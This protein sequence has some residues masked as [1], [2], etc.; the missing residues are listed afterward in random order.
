MRIWAASKFDLRARSRNRVRRYRWKPHASRRGR[1]HL[2]RGSRPRSAR[3]MREGAVTRMG[4]DGPFRLARGAL[5]APGHAPFRGDTSA[6]IFPELHHEISRSL[7]T[8]RSWPV[9]FH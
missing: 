9:D 7:S 3:G 8:L 4:G 5:L 2:S 6:R 1:S